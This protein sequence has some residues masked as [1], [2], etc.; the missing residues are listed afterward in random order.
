MTPKTPAGG[1]L[2]TENDRRGTQYNTRS[3]AYSMS[4]LSTTT[5]TLPVQALHALSHS[6]GPHIGRPSCVTLSS[7]LH[8][9]PEARLKVRAFQLRNEMQ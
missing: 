4:I 7:F 5:P 6:V 8:H 3:L 9:R 2:A 1:R